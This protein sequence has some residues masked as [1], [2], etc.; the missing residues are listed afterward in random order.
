MKTPIAAITYALSKQI[1]SINAIGGDHGWIPLDEDDLKAVK[2]LLRQ[3]F[4]QNALQAKRPEQNAKH[5]QPTQQE[6]D[7]NSFFAMCKK[8]GQ[9]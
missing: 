1:S 9:S 5:Y 2:K 7:D 4:E 6:L 3:R 8:R